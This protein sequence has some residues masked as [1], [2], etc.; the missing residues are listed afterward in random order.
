MVW[1]VI[2]YSTDGIFAFDILISFF[3]A[4]YDKNDELVTSN[5][6]IILHYGSGWFLFDFLGVK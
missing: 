2:D 3:C 4:Y 1:Y 6:K 5:K